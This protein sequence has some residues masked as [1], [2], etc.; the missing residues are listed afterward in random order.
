MV[1]FKDYFTGQVQPPFKTASTSQKC[2][3]AGGKHNDLENV[4]YT[5]RHHTFFEMLGNFS[6]GDYFKEAA[7]YHAWQVIT[8]EFSLPKNRLCITVFAQ[9]DEAAALWKK[10]TGFHED[11][12]I[13]INS[14]DN[15][16]AM[17]DTGPCGPCSEIFYDYG[18]KVCGGP[19][20]SKDSDGDRFTELWNLVFMQYEQLPDS[21]ILLPKPSID[22]GMG[23]ERI[24]SVLQG[25]SNNFDTDLF[26][27]L[28]GEVARLLYHATGFE[29][30]KGLADACSAGCC[31]DREQPEI[32]SFNVVADHIR[33]MCFLI[34]D[35]VL[36]RNDG[37][38]YVLR[39]IMRRAMRHVRNLGTN[40][41][42]LFGLVDKLVELMGEQYPELVASSELC[43]RVILEE[44]HRFGETLGYGMKLVDEEIANLSGKVLPGDV[45][46]KLYD[47]YGFPVDLTADI[48][49]ARGMTIDLDGF[50]RAMD[51]QKKRSQ[52]AGTLGLSGDV[53]S[54]HFER[55]IADLPQTVK[56]CYETTEAHDV[57]ILAIS[58]TGGDV[59]GEST[60]TRI[61][62]YWSVFDKTPFFAKSGGQIGDTGRVF[63]ENFELEVQEVFAVSDHIIHKCKPV[64]GQLP[65]A[66]EI[67]SC[68]VSAVVDKAR[69]QR[70]RAH[71]S[72]THLLQAALRKILGSHVAQS[73]SSLDENRLRF[74]FTHHSP[75][76]N[77]ER[78][79]IED[80]VNAQVLQATPSCIVEYSAKEAKESGVLAF[81]G[82]KYGERVRIVRLGM[83]G[84]EKYYS[85]EFCGGTHVSNTGEV[86]VF[87][88][89]SEAGIAAGVRRI[90]AVCGLAALDY[91]RE[92]LDKHEHEKSELL[93]ENKALAQEINK[94]KAASSR[95]DVETKDFLCKAGGLRVCRAANADRQSIHELAHELWGNFTA[96]S[97]ENSE[98]VLIVYNT[99][100][101]EI[102]FVV[103]VS[104]GLSK[105]VG[106]NDLVKEL[107]AHIGGR[108]GG[109]ARVA[110]GNGKNKEELH[111][112][113]EAVMQRTLSGLI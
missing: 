29:R 52:K 6:F 75:V 15:F 89:V 16:W 82:E 22:T 71:H 62:G 39:R 80:D 19:P 69:R 79:L 36:P 34:A 101:D 60:N 111:A 18:D 86:G 21:R 53:M 20:G 1:Q 113:I 88:I 103:L 8:Q 108:G 85:E 97:G 59:G 12:I 33:A 104:E 109:K 100:A 44:E 27:A 81:F 70:I 7:I 68:K 65:S 26:Q 94:M 23:L 54:L 87:K 51:E 107:C 110:Q 11:K 41:P 31:G 45:V 4:G 47:T 64:R 83:V 72:G 3:R 32:Q 92:C 30:Y 67:A 66:Q 37:R 112:A 42:I 9:D 43:R 55:T 48:L 63:S 93:K 74:D 102:P 77:E 35:G 57:R 38:G 106:A 99:I 25:K 105:S 46:F 61:S 56:L 96:K 84:D 14:S 5:A 28:K 2:V 95:S 13:R 78:K 98:K 17:G 50:E 49:R 76:S 10:I 73:G 91:L 24:A 58:E 40:E 90:E